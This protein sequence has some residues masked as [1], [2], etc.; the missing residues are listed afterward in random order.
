MLYAAGSIVVKVSTNEDGACTQEYFMGHS[1]YVSSIDVFHMEEG[2]DMVAT[3]DVGRESKICVWSSSNLVP[4]VAIQSLHQCGISKLNFSPS[5]ELLLT[6]DNGDANSIAVYNWREQKFY[7]HPNFQQTFT[8]APSCLLTIYLGCAREKQ[9]S[10]R[11][12]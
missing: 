12:E 1:G 10:F 3:A 5:G 4:I 2:G 8:T 11:P 6:L 9:F 7:L